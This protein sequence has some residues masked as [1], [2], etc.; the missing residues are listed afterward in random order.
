LKTIKSADQS[1][2]VSKQMFEYSYRQRMEKVQSS[3]AVIA[4]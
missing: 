1:P 3:L 4:K 2:A